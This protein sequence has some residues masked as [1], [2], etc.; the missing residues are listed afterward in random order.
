MD[1]AHTFAAISPATGAAVWRGPEIDYRRAGMHVLSADEIAEIDGALRHLRA[2]G[3]LD[4]PEIT[5]EKF[6]LPRFGRFLSGLSDQ[7]RHGPGF[8]LLRGLPCERYDLDDLALIYFG[9]GAHVGRVVPQSY[10]G[11][12]LGHVI[13]V[14]D[15]EPEVRGYRAG[16][17]QNMHTDTCDIITLF[18]TREAKSGG[19]SRITSAGDVHNRLLRDRPELLA[20][21]YDGYVFRR[22]E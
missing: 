15:L 20:R 12:L 13:D 8:M 21:L 22:M 11:E 18:C 16:G 14:S 3:R 7:L 9:I 2:L 10:L 17:A 1:Q 19:L 6:P 5:A 4:F